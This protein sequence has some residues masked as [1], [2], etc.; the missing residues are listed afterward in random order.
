VLSA[1]HDYGPDPFDTSSG[2][3]RQRGDGQRFFFRR[4]HLFLSAGATACT[5]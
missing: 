4:Q 5:S 2:T 1:S 3:D